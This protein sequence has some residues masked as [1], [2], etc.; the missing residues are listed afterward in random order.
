MVALMPLQWKVADTERL[1]MVLRKEHSGGSISEFYVPTDEV[2]GSVGGYLEYRD[3]VLMPTQ[4]VWG[5]WQYVLQIRWTPKIKK[6]W[7]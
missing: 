4:N 6:V 7:T 2:G 3:E 1:E 5:N